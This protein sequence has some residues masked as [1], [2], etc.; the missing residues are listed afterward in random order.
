MYA[1]TTGLV[2]IAMM[3]KKYTKAAFGTDSTQYNQ[4]SGLEFSRPK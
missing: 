3:V 4:I 1:D 2:D